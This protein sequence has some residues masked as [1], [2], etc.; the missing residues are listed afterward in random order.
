M[1]TYFLWLALR[2][3][4]KQRLRTITVFCSILLSSFLLY[5]FCGMGY[6]FWV[7]VHGGHLETAV[8]DSSQR[9][10][11]ALAAVLAGIVFFC[12]AV[13]I[14]NL[15][16]LTFPQKWASLYRLLL[17]GAAGR[18]LF[19]LAAVELGTLFAAA[20]PSGWMLAQ[21]AA[22]L[23]GISPGMPP[24]IAGCIQ[25]WLFALSCFYGIR[26]VLRAMR[27][28][29]LV[30]GV[31]STAYFRI[32]QKR[33][34]QKK[35][36][37][38]P[39]YLQALREKAGTQR[40]QHHPRSFAFYMSK[41]YYLAGRRQYGRIA[42]TIAAAILL[43]VPASYLV[44]TNLQINRTGLYQT[45]GITYSCI[46]S[47]QAQLYQGIDEC[48]Y[49]QDTAKSAA[50]MCYVK[51]PGTASIE[52]G[53]LSSR[54]L[55][56]LEKSGWPHGPQFSANSSIYFLE[57]TNYR[58][59]IR[60]CGFQ[61]P[62]SLDLHHCPA[63]LVNRYINRTSYLSRQDSRQVGILSPEAP[64]LSSAAA[65]QINKNSGSANTSASRPVSGK[66]GSTASKAGIKIYCG[67]LP[68]Q[69]P[70]QPETRFALS[71]FICTDKLPEGIEAGDV[72]AILPLGVLSSAPVLGPEKHSPAIFGIE[73]CGLFADKDETLFETLK[74]ELGA[75]AAG[76]LRNTR[77]EFQQ[78]YDSL[79]EIHVAIS[80]ICGILFFTALFH[81]FSTMLFHCLQRCHGFAV[82]W[83]LGQARQ[84]LAAV[85]VLE[86]IR[87]FLR[88]AVS[89][90]PV[91]CVLC[92]FI[93]RV[94]RNVWRIEF[95]LP[96]TQM[97]QIAA[98]AVLALAVAVAAGCVLMG[99]RDFLREIR[100]V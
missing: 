88:A 48:R 78:W 41:K 84:G 9:V 55:D 86:S 18:E 36:K 10:L 19:F 97:G 67:I 45:Y 49:L 92:Y 72:A 40:L 17:L 71:D 51:M 25:V 29:F 14:R 61:Q 5:A 77:Q 12:S 79:H 7:Q 21:A 35:Y 69:A 11:A 81:I 50:A 37:Q 96:Y 65:G 76:K 74:Q 93:Y 95:C 87:S 98:A 80:A 43:Y 83:S 59:Y 3:M 47:D 82:L 15:F 68:D 6:Y 26:P 91:S 1:K 33:H 99:R 90:I 75:G 2:L 53:L 24:W 8:F 70:G 38:K 94:Y 44:D 31:A 73:V 54:L 52:A 58:A 32:P 66:T 57:E 64:L 16:A 56:V 100:N 63:V 13:F 27:G 42:F 4:K 85:L 22:R 20:S 34:R 30:S 62:A 39:L 46:P 60:D 28:P 89:G 23:A